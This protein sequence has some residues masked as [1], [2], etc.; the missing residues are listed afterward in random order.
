MMF[1]QS[2]LVNVCLELSPSTRASIIDKGNEFK[3]KSRLYRPFHSIQSI[4]VEKEVF[5]PHRSAE[6]AE[7]KVFV[8]VT[9]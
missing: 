7:A 4:E 5:P 1:V 9:E 8:V 3:K 2:Y 6:K